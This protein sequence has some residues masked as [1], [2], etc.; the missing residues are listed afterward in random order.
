MYSMIFDFFKSKNKN[1]KNLTAEEF[2]EGIK[3]RDAVV[4]DVRTPG[5]FTAGKIRSAR[6]IAII[7]PNFREQVIH[8]PKDKKYYLYCQSGNR[9]KKACKIMHETGF[10]NLNHLSGG[11]KEWPFEIV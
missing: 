8:L 9:S 10:Q 2:A 5:E 3:F 11:L 1:Y 4:I 6:N 7:N